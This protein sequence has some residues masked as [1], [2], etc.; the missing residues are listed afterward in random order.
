LFVRLESTYNTRIDTYRQA[1]ITVEG[2]TDAEAI[3]WILE[4]ELAK[5]K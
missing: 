4:A 1:D 3:I 5:Q 2:S